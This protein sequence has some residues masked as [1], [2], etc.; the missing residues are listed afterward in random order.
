MT[1]SEYNTY[2]TGSAQGANG[3]QAGRPAT[4]VRL[5]NADQ[6]SPTQM[7]KYRMAAQGRNGG[8]SIW[9]K[10]G[11]WVLTLAAIIGGGYAVHTHGVAYGANG[12]RKVEPGDFAKTIVEDL[13]YKGSNAFN[14]AKIFIGNIASKKSKNS[15]DAETPA[16]ID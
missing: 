2:N 6:P 9:N 13:G 12:R 5:A 4:T 3:Y 16:T 1:Y 15:I 10:I 11:G 8:K 14:S 7:Q